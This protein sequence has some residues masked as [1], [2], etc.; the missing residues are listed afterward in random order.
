MLRNEYRNRYAALFESYDTHEAIVK[1][2]ATSWSGM[3]RDQVIETGQLSSGGGFTKAIEELELS[4]FVTIDLLLDRADRCINICEMKFSEKPYV[5]SKSY[6]SILESKLRVF[7]ARS[8]RQR[9]L[10]L[11]MITPNG[12]VPNRYTEELITNQVVLSDLFATNRGL[13]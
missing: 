5:I 12:T 7:G 10:F 2:L 3:T 6:A 9:A 13:T 8:N 11:T 1:V 4:G